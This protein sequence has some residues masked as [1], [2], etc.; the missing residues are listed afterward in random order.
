M[1][2]MDNIQDK[3]RV[4]MIRSLLMTCMTCV[5]WLNRIQISELI[6]TRM[7]FYY[8][9][10]AFLPLVVTYFYCNQKHSERKE[11]LLSAILLLI[12]MNSWIII[13]PRDGINNFSFHILHSLLLIY[14]VGRR[15]SYTGYI[16]FAVA[17]MVS[18]FSLQ[19]FGIDYSHLFMYAFVM[20]G[21]L[22]YAAHLTSLIQS[23]MGLRKKVD[24]L[25]TLYAIQKV[26]DSFPDIDT[27]ISHITRIVAYGIDVDLCAVLLYS[28]EKDGLELRGQFPNDSVYIQRPELKLAEE[29]FK[30]GV[31]IVC[32]DLDKDAGLLEK[33]DYCHRDKAIGILP[34]EHDE[35]RYGTILFTKNES[36]EIGSGVL[37]VVEGVASTVAMV[38]SNTIFHRSI[39]RRSQVDDLT[40]LFNRSYFFESLDTE[41]KKAKLT[42][43]GVH[44]LLFDIDR[45]KAINDVYGHL[46]GDRVIEEVGKIL[47]ENTR[48]S[49]IPA[50]YG[51]EEFAVILPNSCYSAA[52]HI[53]ER[54]RRS[55]EGM[56]ERISDLNALSDKVTMSI[57]I[58]C[59]PH[60]ATDPRQVLDIADKRMYAA[61]RTG[62][63]QY[64]FK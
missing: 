44:V 5:V 62:G 22:I 36:M 41:I 21:A 58:A 49:D 40:G 23:E 9:V 59:Y 32:H 54:V 3:Y 55:V 48:K 1:N 34:L 24:E 28:Q 20:V 8:S 35:I 52:E 14:A 19:L 53:A 45:F 4:L 51:G 61:K 15:A 56:S 13:G 27:V 43:Q 6:G 47:R 12:F 57:G 16:M 17:L 33:I 10:L 2:F 50:R 29:V 30:T 11:V 18:L 42:E 46:T 7:G 25:E 37:Q 64:I 31:P 38:L 39:L 26:I 63:N 60:C